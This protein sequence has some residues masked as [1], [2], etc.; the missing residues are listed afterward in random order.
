MEA[1]AT[2]TLVQILHPRT[3]T[4]LDHATSSTGRIAHAEKEDALWLL[5]LECWCRK[6]HQRERVSWMSRV[7]VGG[8]QTRGASFH[9][10]V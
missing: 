10:S 1:L 5:S 2:W 6:G 4:L 9:K 8:D 7:P 3:R